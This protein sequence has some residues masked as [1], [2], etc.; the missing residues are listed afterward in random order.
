MQTNIG[1]NSWHEQTLTNLIQAGLGHKRQ[2]QVQ[3]V[4]DEAPMMTR[5]GSWLRQQSSW[6]S[7]IHFMKESSPMVE[8]KVTC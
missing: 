1:G 3:Q 8:L 4:A 2:V 6:E 5:F 7:L